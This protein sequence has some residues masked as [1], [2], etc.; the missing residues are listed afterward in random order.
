MGKALFFAGEADA[1]RPACHREHPAHRNGG[2]L[3]AGAQ[4]LVAAFHRPGKRL[5]LCGLPGAAPTQVVVL[6]LALV[7]VEGDAAA[8]V[9]GGFL[10]DVAL[11]ALNDVPGRGAQSLAAMLT[12]LKPV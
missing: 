10:L 7:R 2:V 8:A 1:G 12:A 5:E 6:F 11:R 4:L 3:H 9:G